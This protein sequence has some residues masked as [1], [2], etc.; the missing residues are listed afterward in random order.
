MASKGEEIEDNFIE[1][2]IYGGLLAEA[3]QS[4][5]FHTESKEE[6]HLLKSAV[7]KAKQKGITL[8]ISLS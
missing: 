2:H 1:V 6:V 3:I 7:R 5:K 8:E 4:I